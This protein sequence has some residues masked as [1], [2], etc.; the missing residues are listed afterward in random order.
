[1][2]SGPRTGVFELAADVCVLESLRHRREVPELGPWLGHVGL[3]AWLG[4]EL[5]QPPLVLLK[6][7]QCIPASL[8]I[9]RAKR[10]MTSGNASPKA[11][12]KG[13]CQAQVCEDGEEETGATQ[14]GL[15]EE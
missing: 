9:S 12:A 2:H 7:L 4:V 3:A 13:L 15:G 6:W 11:M 14:E 8:L 1:M 5:C 10:T